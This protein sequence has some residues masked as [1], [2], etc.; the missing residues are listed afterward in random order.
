MRQRRFLPSLSQLIAFEAV[1]RHA[2]VT[3]AADELHLTQSTVSRLVASLERQLGK[4]LFT[5]DRKRLTPTAEAAVYA[6]SVT[7][8]LDL[9]QRASMGLIANPGGGVLSLSVLPTFATRWLAP[10][11]GQFLADNP[12]I[13][14][15]LSTKIQRFSFASEAFD[16]VIYFGQP[17]WPDAHHVKLFDERLTAC[18]S[19]AF[20]ARHQ[21]AA[22]ADMAGLAMLQLETRPSG[23][24]AWVAAQGGADVAVSG[25]VMDQFSMMIQAAIS[26][27]G[28]ALLPS[29]LAQP[30]IDEGRLVPILRPAVPGE[31]AY[32][33]AW[34]D[35][36]QGD[37]AFTRFRAWIE[38]QVAQD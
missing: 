14:I 21:I 27:L 26:G 7:Q 13:S 34:P 12:G 5:R 29:Y 11:I 33:L 20:L 8:G 28:V 25:M 3:A 32:W 22:P 38:A 16:A 37:P 31:G 35:R 17:D 18:A 36:R 6:A 1:M 23:W 15:N 2:S 19:P 10:R 9:I 30:E 24:Q 4:P